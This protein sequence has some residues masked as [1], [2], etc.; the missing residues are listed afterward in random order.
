MGHPR[1]A[2]NWALASNDD[3]A[4]D[5]VGTEQDWLIAALNNRPELQS[6]I[7]ELPS[8]RRGSNPRR[9][10]PP[11]RHSRRCPRR[12]RPRLAFRPHPLHPPPPLRLGQASRAKA[13]AQRSA[14]RH[15]LL[16]QQP[17]GHS[18]NPPRL[19]HRSRRPPLPPARP[20]PPP[21]APKRPARPCHAR[22]QLGD[23]DLSTALLAQGDYHQALTRAS[24]LQER[25]EL[26]RIKLERAAGGAGFAA[27]IPTTKPSTQEVSP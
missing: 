10:V 26:A 19:R 18:R 3:A 4:A 20:H 5:I 12:A 21:P 6:K 2:L 1:S 17:R 25:A 16:E 13:E 27:A 11:Q 22:I 8:P 23:A 7:W 24:Q 14:A 15:D 9:P